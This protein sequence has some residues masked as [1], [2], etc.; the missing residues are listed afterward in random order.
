MNLGQSLFEVLFA[1]GIA[2]IIL[3]A[4]VSLS[5]QSVKTSDASKNNSLATKYALEGIEWVRQQRDNTV[6]ATFSSYA[7]GVR[8][9]GDLNWTSGSS[10]IGT[11]IFHR[12]IQ[13]TSS[14]ADTFIVE[15]RVSWDDSGGA[16]EVKNTTKLTNWRS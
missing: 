13:L 6:W 4:V 11:S 1:V 10:Q 14:G 16:H 3:I 9:L 12:T 5:V 15:I 2:A 8:N 7:G